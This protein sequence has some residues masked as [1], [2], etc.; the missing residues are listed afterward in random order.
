MQNVGHF[1]HRN[2]GLGRFGHG[3]FGHRKNAKD[4]RFGHNHKLWAGLCA[5]IIGMKFNFLVFI[6]V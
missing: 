4:G 1:G 2:F 6:D 5:C 3:R